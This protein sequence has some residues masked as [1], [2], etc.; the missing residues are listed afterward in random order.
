MPKFVLSSRQFQAWCARWS[1]GVI[2]RPP[3]DRIEAP[4]QIGVLVFEEIRDAEDEFE[5]PH[6]AERSFAAVEAPRDAS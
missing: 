1:A 6:S 5:L 4:R 2:N 3:R